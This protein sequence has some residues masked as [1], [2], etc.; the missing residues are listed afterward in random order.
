[1]LSGKPIDDIKKIPSLFMPVREK[2]PR[3]YS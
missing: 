2:N 3:K 1:M